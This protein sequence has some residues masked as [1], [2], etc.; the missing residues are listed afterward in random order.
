VTLHLPEHLSAALNLDGMPEIGLYD[1]EKLQEERG[2]KVL[3][4]LTAARNLAATNFPLLTQ[5]EWMLLLNVIQYAHKPDQWVIWNLALQPTRHS[6]LINEIYQAYGKE[7]IDGL[8]MS[9]LDRLGP[10]E[11][12][13][14]LLVADRFWTGLNGQCVDLRE[15]LSAVSKRPTES[16]F[17]DDPTTEDRG[18]LGGQVDRICQRNRR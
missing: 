11:T 18:P 10:N 1:A 3:A 12:F 16:V 4:L 7:M 8:D 15:V 13:S 2:H 9:R 5:T 17:C 14:I 6:F